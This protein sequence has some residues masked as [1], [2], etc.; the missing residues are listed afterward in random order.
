MCSSSKCSKCGKLS[1]TG[2]GNHLD[3]LF[4]GKQ[5]SELCK[6]NDKIVK[7]IKEKKLK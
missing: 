3:K 7:Y 1:F 4:T 6:C 5:A 2:C